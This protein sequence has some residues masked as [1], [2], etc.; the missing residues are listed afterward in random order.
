MRIILSILP[1]IPIPSFRAFV[2]LPEIVE[3]WSKWAT[4]L[5][6]SV[7]IVSLI[8]VWLSIFYSLIVFGIAF[9]VLVTIN[10][11]VMHIRVRKFKRDGKRQTD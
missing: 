11:V 9:I 3:K 1:N 5:V 7:L 2:T 10:L 4:A 8:S 6:L